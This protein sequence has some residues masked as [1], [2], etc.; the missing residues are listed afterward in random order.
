MWCVM[1]CGEVCVVRCGVVRCGVM[2]C[3]EVVCGEVW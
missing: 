1:W 3:G 2:W